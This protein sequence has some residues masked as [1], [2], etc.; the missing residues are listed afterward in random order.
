MQGQ[1]LFTYCF[2]GDKRHQL[3]FEELLP[4][5]INTNHFVTRD[6]APPPMPQVNAMA[7]VH[8]T[9]PATVPGL[10]PHLCL[11]F[12]AI[13]C[14]EP[15]FPNWPPLP[16][17]TSK[18]ALYL[19]SLWLMPCPHLHGIGGCPSFASLT[20]PATNWVD[21]CPQ[22]L[23]FSHLTPCLVLASVINPYL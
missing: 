1:V 23:S 5:H 19:P 20:N 3:L 7:S 8:P 18:S 15:L 16:S 4:G 21:I 13:F 17:L 11:F 9:P 10:P 12:K 2:F 22:S 14:Q 6:Q